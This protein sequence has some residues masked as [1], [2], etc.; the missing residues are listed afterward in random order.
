MIRPLIVLTLMLCLAAVPVRAAAPAAAPAANQFKELN[1]D[2]DKYAFAKSY[3]QSLSYYG[4]LTKRLE[5]EKSVGDKYEADLAAVQ[6][7]LDNRTLDNTELRVAKNYL[8]KYAQ[9]RNM[10]IRRVAYDTMVAYENHILLSSRERQLWTAY[11]QF[12]SKGVP[13]DLNEMEFKRQIA[14]LARDRKNVS[15]SLLQQIMIFQKVLLSARLC[16]SEDCKSLALTQAERDKLVAK[17]DVFASDNMAWGMKPGQGTFEAAV[18]ALR[19]LLEDPL[20]VSR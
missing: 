8:L 15:L 13:R 9:A 1:P 6:T 10:L 14:N 2:I 5:Q 11:Y 4:R 7:I 19:E 18:A 16:E 17:L 20:Y 12:K 3:I